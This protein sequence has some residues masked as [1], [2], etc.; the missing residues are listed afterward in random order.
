MTSFNSV[1]T[2]S[3]IEYILSLPEVQIAKEKVDLREQGSAY[4]TIELTDTIRTTLQ[5]RFNLDFS[6]VSNIPMRWIKGDSFPHID[7][8]VSNFEKTYLIYLNDNPGQFLIGDESYSITQNTGYMFDEGVSHSTTNTGS[9]PRLLLGPMNELAEPVG[10]PVYYYPT[11]SDAIAQTNLLTQSGTYTII[12]YSGFNYWRIASNSTGSS[13]QSTVYT[14][15]DSLN[16]DGA[17]YLYPNIPCFL[18]GTTILCQVN[19]IEKYV[20]IESIQKGMFVKTSRDGY[21]MVQIV[22]RSKISN[23]GNSQRTK[24]RLYRCSTTKYPS[25]TSDL[26]VTG[27]HSILEFPITEKQK[28]DSIK[29]LGRLFVTDKK[30]RI[31][32][33]VDERAEP[34]NSEGVYT[35]YHFALENKDDGMNYGVYANGGLLVESCSIRTLQNRS[36]MKL[37]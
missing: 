8:A 22:G 19:G 37:I 12:S 35:I 15:N 13:S 25:L 34:W 18:E 11:E 24:D 9:V 10:S 6:N 26:Y 4:F 23:P 28:E 21:K 29:E 36:N 32:A 5:T 17:Y 2:Q 27:C 3:D 30:Y 14:V 33:C 1:L 7:R 16:G 31:M 20:P